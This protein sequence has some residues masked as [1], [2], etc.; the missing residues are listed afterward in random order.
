MLHEQKKINTAN[1]HSDFAG[2][3]VANNTSLHNDF[4]FVHQ[5]GVMAS[6]GMY[7]G[8][9]LVTVATLQVKHIKFQLNQLCWTMCV[10]FLTI[11]QLKYVMHNVYNGLFWFTFPVLLV[12]VNDV[13]AYVCGMTCGRKFIN[14][15]FLKLSPNKTWEGFIGGGIFT[16]FIGVFLAKWLASYNWMTCP[17]DMPSIYSEALKCE[18]NPL[19]LEGYH[20]VPSQVSEL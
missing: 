19:F 8:V 13:M 6:F 2:S 5:F 14:K 17:V 12:V 3:F 10:L 16:V 4:W 7:A 18:P 9:F 1:N 11:G 15:T 20:A